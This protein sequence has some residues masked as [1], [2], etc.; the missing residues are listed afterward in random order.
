MGWVVTE[1]EFSGN[2][3]ERNAENILV[4]LCVKVRTFILCIISGQ[5]KVIRIYLPSHKPSNTYPKDI[6]AK[7]VGIVSPPLHPAWVPTTEFKI[8]IFGTYTTGVNWPQILVV[9]RNIL[10]PTLPPILQ[11][12]ESPVEKSFS[13]CPNSCN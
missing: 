13:Y 4:W 1:W 10:T 5:L 2:S 6:W 8:A 9:Q 7:R 3:R 12:R 11:L